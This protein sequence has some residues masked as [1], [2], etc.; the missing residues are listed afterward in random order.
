MNIKYCDGNGSASEY[1]HSIHDQ[2]S[3]SMYMKSCHRFV[4]EHRHT[5]CCAYLQ[6]SCHSNV[7]YVN[8]LFD[9]VHFLSEIFFFICISHES[10]ARSSHDRIGYILIN[11]QMQIST[12]IDLLMADT[13]VCIFVIST[14]RQFVYISKLFAF[15]HFVQILRFFFLLQF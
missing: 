1:G 3:N 7:R 8:H 13:Y 6:F 14:A 2:N 9:F 10:I 11:C 15:E 4:C 12:I 5:F